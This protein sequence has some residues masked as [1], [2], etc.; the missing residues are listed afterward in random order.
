MPQRVTEILFK[1]KHLI[2]IE[3]LPA[4]GPFVGNLLKW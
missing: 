3:D 4:R 2:L 1:H